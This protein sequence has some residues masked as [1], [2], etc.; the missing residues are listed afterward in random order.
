MSMDYKTIEYRERIS[1][2]ILLIGLACWGIVVTF[3]TS[4]SIVVADGVGLSQVTYLQSLIVFLILVWLPGIFMWFA[5]RVIRFKSMSQVDEFVMKWSTGYRIANIF[6]VFFNINLIDTIRCFG[7]S[8]QT[9]WIVLSNGIVRQ[10]AFLINLVMQ[11]AGQETMLQLLQW[12]SLIKQAV[13]R[14]LIDVNSKSK[15]YLDS[16]KEPPFFERSF[17]FGFYAPTLSYCLMIGMMFGF[18]CPLM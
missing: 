18:I 17:V 12:R 11:A 13:I 8:P 4:F 16:L 2:F 6:F 10:S 9:I 5:N 1:E 7:E 3:I 14:P 15:R